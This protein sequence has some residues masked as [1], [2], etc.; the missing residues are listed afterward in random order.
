MSTSVPGATSPAP[1]RRLVRSLL[2]TL[3]GGVA[4]GVAAQAAAGAQ[5]TVPDGGDAGSGDATTRGNGPASGADAVP[6][7][8]TGDVGNAGVAGE[9]LVVLQDGS[10]SKVGLGVGSLDGLA[11]E[12]GSTTDA[13]SGSAVVSSA[14]AE[15]GA[16]E[17]NSRLLQAADDGLVVLAERAS[18]GD[19]SSNATVVHTASAGD[20]LSSNGPPSD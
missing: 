11:H 10:L 8:P 17:S 3:S 9:V 18:V 15:P 16:N 13:S 2:L 7:S 12:S 19:G 1:N 6:A 14:A 20:V 5:G 4:L